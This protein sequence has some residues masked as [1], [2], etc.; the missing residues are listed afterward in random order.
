MSTALHW[1]VN[2][3]AYLCRGPELVGVEGEVADEVL[4][5]GRRL[6]QVGGTGLQLL[7]GAGVG[8]PAQQCGQTL[9]LAGHRQA[10]PGQD[11]PQGGQGGVH[12]TSAAQHPPRLPI[13]QG[14]TG[15]L[16]TL[17][18]LHRCMASSRVGRRG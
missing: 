14:Q 11:Q 9:Q 4:G 6:A 12:H 5:P 17:A 16:Q 10:G 13:Y 18:A 15:R 2:D 3:K 7:G 1:L 8:G